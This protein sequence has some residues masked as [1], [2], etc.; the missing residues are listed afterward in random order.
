LIKCLMSKCSYIIILY[1][2][3]RPLKFIVAVKIS[4]RK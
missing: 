2:N 4:I 1:R 3:R